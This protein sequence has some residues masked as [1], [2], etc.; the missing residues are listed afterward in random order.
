MVIEPTPRK[1]KHLVFVQSPGGFVTQNLHKGAVPMLGRQT[2]P[3]RLLGQ[4]AMVKKSS[5][6]GVNGF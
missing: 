6:A 2:N 1:H 4:L 5:A 3:Q